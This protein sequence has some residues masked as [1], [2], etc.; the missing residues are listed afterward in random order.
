MLTV[1][2]SLLMIIDAQGNL[3]RV[4]Q[5]SE[6]RITAITR[7][8][9]ACQL[10]EIPI[11]LTAQA[12]EKIGHTIEEVRSLLPDHLEYPRLHFSIWP[13]AD[14]R[15]ALQESQRRQIM[16]CGFESHICLY[17]SAM[18]LLAVGYEP[19]MMVDALSSRAETNKTTALQELRAE[20]VHLS[21]VEMALFALMRTA[22]HQ[23]FKPISRLI[24]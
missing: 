1:E 5:D 16:L 10:L 21:T 23:Q 9:Q 8:I 20:G 14:L 2:N 3:A 15:Q 11:L 18:D 13:E 4:V 19:W 24:K 6:A 22:A 12:P 7:L 17:Q